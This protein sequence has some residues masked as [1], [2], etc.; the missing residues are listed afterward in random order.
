V[1]FYIAGKFEERPSVK[2]LQNELIKLGHEITKDWTLDEEDEPGYPVINAVE[3]V[4]G[5][6]MAGAY[7]GLY[8]NSHDYKG[9]LVEMGVALGARIPL[10]II[11][12][13]VD[14]CIFINH[15]LVETFETVG[16]FLEWIKPA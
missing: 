10:Y 13:A 16:E 12:H 4:R 6:K 5:V 14:S 7:V 1:K 11:G 15:P 8:I 3:D 9:A 2:A